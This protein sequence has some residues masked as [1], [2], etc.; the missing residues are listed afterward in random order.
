MK[1]ER[2]ACSLPLLGDTEH[3][4][5]LAWPAVTVFLWA[6]QPPELARPGSLPPPS[7]TRQDPAQNSISRQEFGYSSQENNFTLFFNGELKLLHCPSHMEAYQNPGNKHLFSS[8]ALNVS[9]DS[10]VF[11][12]ALMV[13]GRE[14][15]RCWDGRTALPFPRD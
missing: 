8:W 14:D 2:E 15:E 1:D 7:Q 13:G 4:P 11:S 12:C 5:A 10:D 3:R 9:P 6:L